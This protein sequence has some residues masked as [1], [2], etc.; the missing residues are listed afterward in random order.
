MPR[1]KNGVVPAMPL[2][3]GWEEAKAADGKTYYINH[4]KKNTSWIDPR[5]R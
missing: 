3:A 5:D 2:P 1:Q 4:N